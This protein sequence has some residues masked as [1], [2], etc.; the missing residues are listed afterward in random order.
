MTTFE[1][2]TRQECMEDGC[3]N[4]GMDCYLPDDREQAS[5]AYCSEHAFDEGFCKG[6]GQFWGGV[7]SFEFLNGGYC[8]ECRAALDSEM[9]DE[10]DDEEA[11]D[12]DF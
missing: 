5:Y 4:E 12:D 11:F 7:E 2:G 3:A 6:C 1:T 8:D 10:N 9:S